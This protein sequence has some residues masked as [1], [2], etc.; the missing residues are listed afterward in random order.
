MSSQVLKGWEKKRIDN[1][2]KSFDNYGGIKM[3]SIS[4]KLVS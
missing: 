2:Y 4:R 3:K 1:L